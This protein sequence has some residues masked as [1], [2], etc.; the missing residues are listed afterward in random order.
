M[1]IRHYLSTT[2]I[3]HTGPE[4]TLTHTGEANGNPAE[5]RRVTGFTESPNVPAPEPG[6]SSRISDKRYVNFSQ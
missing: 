5:M 6:Y 4:L 2:K 3:D 1:H